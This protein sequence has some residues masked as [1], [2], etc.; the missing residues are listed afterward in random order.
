M[1]AFCTRMTTLD[2]GAMELRLRQCLD[3]RI[4]KHV[5]GASKRNP[6][7]ST[8]TGSWEMVSAGRG[9]EP[10]ATEVAR[11]EDAARTNPRGY[12]AKSE[13]TRRTQYNFPQRRRS[14][15]M[16]PP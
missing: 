9:L 8:P 1:R 6:S 10:I 12:R 15:A 13:R 14:L 7:P 4:A 16:C 2:D 3:E 5:R 11:R